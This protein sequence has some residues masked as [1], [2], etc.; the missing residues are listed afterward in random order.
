MKSIL[1]YIQ[2][3]ILLLKSMYTFCSYSA[4]V[5]ICSMFFICS[6]IAAFAKYVCAKVG[7]YQM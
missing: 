2:K 5:C 3:Y 6:R 7:E 4:I 1:L